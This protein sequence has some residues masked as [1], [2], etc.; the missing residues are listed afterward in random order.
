MKVEKK[1]NAAG[2]GRLVSQLPEEYTSEDVWHFLKRYLYTY[3]IKAS[4]LIK[5]ITVS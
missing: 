5:N 3:I 2:L 1:Y 4:L